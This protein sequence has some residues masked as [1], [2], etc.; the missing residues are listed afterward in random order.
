MEGG[1]GGMG[2]GFDGMGGAFGGNM[3]GGLGG[4]YGGNMSGVGGG[5]GGNMGR[6]EDASGGAHGNESSPLVENVDKDGGGDDDPNSHPHLATLAPTSREPP[7]WASAP[8]VWVGA[9]PAQEAAYLE[10]WRHIRLAEERRDGEYL[11]MLEH[12]AEAEEVARQAA[13]A[14]EAAQPAPLPAQPAPDMNA[15]WNSAFS[16]ADPAPTLIDL[17]DPKDDD[18]A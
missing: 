11:E 18:D 13:A 2:G 10:H 17:T 9:T 7:V 5:Y 3:M 6:N 12:D 8:L 4:G 16:W 15:L 1:F 14:Q